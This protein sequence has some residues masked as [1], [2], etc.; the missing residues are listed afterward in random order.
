MHCWGIVGCIVMKTVFFMS[1]QISMRLLKATPLVLPNLHNTFV[2]CFS[3]EYMGDNI[4]MARAI[5][6]H[7][8]RREIQKI[9]LI[10]HYL[11]AAP[12][13]TEEKTDFSS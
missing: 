13:M 10:Y 9:S 4:A 3:V 1:N 11:L 2:E 6:K 5:I 8:L 12:V 7:T